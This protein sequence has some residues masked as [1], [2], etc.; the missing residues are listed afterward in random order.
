MSNL[1][2]DAKKGYFTKDC[3]FIRAHLNPEK[4]ISSGSILNFIGLYW[5][6]TELFQHE[7]KKEIL[8][9]P[10]ESG[11]DEMPQTCIKTGIKQ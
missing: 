1:S 4:V 9:L 6:S 11:N 3:A 8:C 5:V 2:C 10:P 7:I